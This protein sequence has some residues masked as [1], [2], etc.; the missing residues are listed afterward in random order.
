SAW[1]SK[2]PACPRVRRIRTARV[3]TNAHLQR[4]NHLRIKL[5]VARTGAA[6]KIQGRPLPAIEWAHLAHSSAAGEAARTAGVDRCGVES[7]WI[8]RRK[9][10]RSDSS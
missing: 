8:K 1:A 9:K 10:H 2:T 3:R 4:A 5:F 6:R 7:G